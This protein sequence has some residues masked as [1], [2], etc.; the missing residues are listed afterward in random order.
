[1]TQKTKLEIIGPYTPEHEGP[2]CTRGGH[3]VRIVCRD[4]KTSIHDDCSIVA[5]IDCGDR[6]LARDFHQSGRFAI[7]DHAFDLMNAREVP[8]AREAELSVHDD[9]HLAKAVAVFNRTPGLTPYVVK[10]VISAW[11]GSKG[12]DGVYV[13]EVLPGEGA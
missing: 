8:V 10:E 9:M 1:M 11:L 13:R 7:H 4:K 2:F 5:L 12:M 6:E 3:P